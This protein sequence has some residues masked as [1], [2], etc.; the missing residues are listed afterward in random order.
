MWNLLVCTG[1]CKWSI[2][3]ADH[4]ADIRTHHQKHIQIADRE[5]VVRRLTV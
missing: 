3:V 1:L 4:S 5:E 2:A